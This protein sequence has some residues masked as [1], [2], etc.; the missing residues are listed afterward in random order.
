MATH[1]RLVKRSSQR[2]S[3]QDLP[4]RVG[5]CGGVSKRCFRRRDV[6]ARRA[7]ATNTVASQWTGQ[8][9]CVRQGS[10]GCGCRS[11]NERP[12][13]L[14]STRGLQPTGAPGGSKCCRNTDGSGY[15]FT[16]NRHTRA[17][18]Q[19]QVRGAVGYAHGHHARSKCCAVAG[20]G[21]GEQDYGGHT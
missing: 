7:F 6:W 13:F 16:A 9:D 14:Y 20:D 4:L 21:R 11:G 17:R 10:P 15:Q 19:L 8:V 2:T 18:F 3:Q 12:A 5:G 1:H